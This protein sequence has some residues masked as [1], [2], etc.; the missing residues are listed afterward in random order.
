M[1]KGQ[2]A[3]WTPIIV[4]LILLAVFVLIVTSSEFSNFTSQVSNALEST[5]Q[6]STGPERYL[7]MAIKLVLDLPPIEVILA[8]ITLVIAIIIYNGF[9]N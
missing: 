2:I 9:Q 4:G 6:K 7:L 8:V 3:D 1:M 5:I